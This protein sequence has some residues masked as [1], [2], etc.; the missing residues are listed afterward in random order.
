MSRLICEH[1]VIVLYSFAL[2][3]ER[4]VFQSCP[5]TIFVTQYYPIDFEV[6]IPTDN[7]AVYEIDRTDN[8]YPGSIFDRASRVRYTAVDYQGLA[9]NCDFWVYITGKVESHL[10][11][12]AELGIIVKVGR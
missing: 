3:T 8:I 9:T 5:D 12:S 4:P 10:F 2:D 11:K 6:P 7:T 1:L